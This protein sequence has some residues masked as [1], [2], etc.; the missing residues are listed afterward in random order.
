MPVIEEVKEDYEVSA[1][2]VGPISGQILSDE[3]ED[4]FFDILSVSEVDT[5]SLMDA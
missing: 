5:E 2:S 3:A 1:V 4:T